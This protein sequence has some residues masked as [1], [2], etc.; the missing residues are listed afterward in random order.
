MEKYA[1]TPTAGPK[2]RNAPGI[3][4][5]R[6]TFNHASQRNTYHVTRIHASMQH[7]AK[8]QQRRTRYWGIAWGTAIFVHLVVFV[9]L[10]WFMKPNY[11]VTVIQMSPK[12]D[13]TMHLQPT[14]A[15]RPVIYFSHTAPSPDAVQLCRLLPTGQPSVCFKAS[16]HHQN[17][18]ALIFEEIVE[19]GHYELVVSETVFASPW[20]FD[21]EYRSAFPSGDGKPGGQFRASF[22]VARRAE[23]I[24]TA[25]TFDATKPLQNT[26]SASGAQTNTPNQGA[27]TTR[28]E[29]VSQPVVKPKPPTKRPQPKKPK[30]S[31]PTKVQQTAQTPSA[32]D[33]SSLENHA[34]PGEVKVSP[35][36]FQFTPETMA[37]ELVAEAADAAE[38]VFRS[39]DTNRFV[40]EAEIER[41]AIQAAYNG[42][43]P[44]VGV[45]M[46]G[47]AVQNDK[48]VSEYLALMH[49]EIHPRWAEG[50]LLRLDSNYRFTNAAL[51][52][53]ELKA[54]TEITLDSLGKVID[55]RMVYSS[56]ISEYDMEAI[57]VSRYSSPGIAP[58]KTMLSP[59]GKA[60][61]HWTFWR[62]MRQCGVFG[63]KVF[64]IKNGREESVDFSLKKVNLIEKRLG[65]P[66]SVLS[67]DLKR[68]PKPVTSV[69]EAPS[70]APL[71]ETIN[72]MD[73]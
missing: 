51:Q 3:K 64:R 2:P 58:P 34:E 66:Q 36:I 30:P 29:A 61:V 13:S 21:G 4:I 16:Q 41:R 24:L 35:K 6:D 69:P 56:G 44:T 10:S 60:Y 33:A 45:G 70:S 57:R 62:D 18:E 19:E 71:P 26:E 14:Q 63:V 27:Q 65:L 38:A 40:A 46:Q 5:F 68:A 1:A 53:S 59:S 7:H 8:Y 32:P 54:A 31:T 43:G 17:P 15:L 49:K 20:Q 28:K 73:D 50:Y 37:P 11:L 72:P 47:N 22:D 12:P 9:C 25:T 39:R 52:N 55:V 67:N 48:D 23:E 42:D